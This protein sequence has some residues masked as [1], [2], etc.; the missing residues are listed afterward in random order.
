M[1][2]DR[3][4][5][6]NTADRPRRAFTIFELQ[7]VIT[8]LTVLLTLLVPSMIGAR[9]AARRAYCASNQKMLLLQAHVYGI[10]Y[11]GAWPRGRT[12]LELWPFWRL[13]KP[14]F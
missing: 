3:A 8:L 14:S 7:A 9:E 10:E 5:E 11:K 13:A 4:L 6:S 1:M 2:A 12:S